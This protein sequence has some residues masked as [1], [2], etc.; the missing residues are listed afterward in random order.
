MT[1][2]IKLISQSISFILIIM[3]AVNLAGCCGR[4]KKVDK[5][6]NNY[7]FA[8]S[9]KK[10]KKKKTS[11]NN[12]TNSKEFS[13]IHID[14]S[15]SLPLRQKDEVSS[16]LY[17][18]LS[19]ANSMYKSRNYDT[20]LREISNIQRQAENDPY[21]KMQTWALLAMIYDKT[22]KNSRRKRS[23]AKMIE[24]MADIQ[25]DARYKKAY[26]DGM[27]CQELIASATQ[28]GDNKYDFK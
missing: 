2:K 7:N 4:K 20:A 5:K 18:K 17:E 9:L 15:E 3:M 22:G 24:S 11:I 16:E 25:K 19:Y 26:E 1:C 8:D 28:K 13:D 12:K 6:N 14:L 23:Y 10:T 27:I 21:L